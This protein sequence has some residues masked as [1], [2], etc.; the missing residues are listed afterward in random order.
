MKAD[1]DKSCLLCW[2]DQVHDQARDSMAAL[3][4]YIRVTT[5]R[6]NVKVDGLDSLRYVMV[7]LKEVRVKLCTERCVMCESYIR[8]FVLRYS[9]M[10]GKPD[11]SEKGHKIPG[12]CLSLADASCRD[13]LK[14]SRRQARRVLETS[15]KAF[16]RRSWSDPRGLNDNNLNES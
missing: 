2:L 6:L 14:P 10:S 11:E 12:R 8:F 13:S 9:R 3:M 4:D 5:T 16:R 7:V 15:A 1:D